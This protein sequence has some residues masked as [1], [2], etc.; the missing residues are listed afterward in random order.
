M[1]KNITKLSDREFDVFKL[2]IDGFK[3]SEIARKLDLK[4]NTIS[5]YKRIILF[6]TGV[7]NTI[8]LFKFALENNIIRK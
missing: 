1:K 4:T 8:E 2:L 7:N 5:T 3:T 6:K